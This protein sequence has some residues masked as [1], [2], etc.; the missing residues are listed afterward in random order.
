[1]MF[2]DVLKFMQAIIRHVKFVYFKRYSV[3]VPNCL[4]VS[5]CPPPRVSPLLTSAHFVVMRCFVAGQFVLVQNFAAEVQVGFSAAS[6]G[7]N[8]TPASA[9]ALRRWTAN[10][11]AA[12]SYAIGYA[13]GVT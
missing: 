5:P 6:A 10:K 4:R 12:P 2:L 11:P 3:T 7:L 8:P 1:M 13:D 9:R